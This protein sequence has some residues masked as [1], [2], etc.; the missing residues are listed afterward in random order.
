MLSKAQRLKGDLSQLGETK[1]ENSPTNLQEVFGEEVKIKH[2]GDVIF[3][4]QSFALETEDIEADI[5]T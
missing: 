5:H 3:M 1:G 4:D 2:P